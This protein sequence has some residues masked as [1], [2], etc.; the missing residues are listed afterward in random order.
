MVALLVIAS[1][2]IFGF[3]CNLHSQS[4]CQC[5]R[6]EVNRTIKPDSIFTFMN[7]KQFYLCGTFDV[8]ESD[9]LYTE[10]VVGICGDS[11]PVAVWDAMAN[12]KI[13]KDNDTIVVSEMHFLP[14]YNDKT[15]VW[16]AAEV[17]KYYYTENTFNAVTVFNPHFTYYDSLAINRV[18]T[19]AVN[20]SQNDKDYLLLLSKKLLVA[21]MSG[22]TEAKKLLMAMPARYGLQDG[23]YGI[24]WK[25][26]IQIYNSWKNLT[27]PK[28]N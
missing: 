26:I 1:F 14:V 6:N 15:P 2:F 5:A 17:N 27:G 23:E 8:Y 11:I 20:P 19:E 9:T 10:M 28:I 13:Y 4:A 25:E 3:T 21:A 7:Q 24:G 16:I 22:S 18:I 12:C